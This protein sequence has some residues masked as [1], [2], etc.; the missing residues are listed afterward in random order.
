M[1]ES[2]CFSICCK[3]RVVNISIIVNNAQILSRNPSRDIKC[4]PDSLAKSRS[5]VRR[6]GGIYVRLLPVHM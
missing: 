6:A 2:C 1:S 4:D 3:V 5:F